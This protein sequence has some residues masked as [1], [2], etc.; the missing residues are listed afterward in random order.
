VGGAQAPLQAHLGRNV[1]VGNRFLHLD[2]RKL[3]RPWGQAL[4]ELLEG[5]L[6]FKE[7]MAGVV[8]G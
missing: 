7:R 6:G 1:R 3:D 2:T 8:V 4:L 5:V